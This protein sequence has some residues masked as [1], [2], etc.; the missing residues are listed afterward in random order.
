MRGTSAAAASTNEWTKPPKVATC[1][2]TICVDTKSTT[3]QNTWA[4]MT[5]DDQHH[6]HHSRSQRHEHYPS[7]HHLH[8]RYH[9]LP[10]LCGTLNISIIQ[11]IIFPKHLNHVTYPHIDRIELRLAPSYCTSTTHVVH[12][13]RDVQG[14]DDRVKHDDG[15]F[16]PPDHYS[17]PIQDTRLSFPMAS[18]EWTNIPESH[19][20]W[21]YIDA[22]V[23]DGPVVLGHGRIIDE[24]LDLVC[25]RDT[26]TVQWM[27]L[28]D[29]VTKEE[30]GMIQIRFDF[31]QHP[32]GHS[33][34]PPPPP[35]HHGA[36]D[37]DPPPHEAP[38][39]TTD[40]FFTRDV[41]SKHQDL[42]RS[43]HELKLWKKLFYALDKDQ[44]GYMDMTEFRSMVT[45]DDRVQTVLLSG[46]S[47]E[48]LMALFDRNGDG[49]GI[50]IPTILMERKRYE[51]ALCCR[52]YCRYCCFRSPHTHTHFVSIR[53]K[54]PLTNMSRACNSFS[55]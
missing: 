6:G 10:L 45:Q 44:S 9:V 42:V 27:P 22:I 48:P 18:F 24:V 14:K 40:A 43:A 50:H 23:F 36:N 19:D 51:S 31:H 33:P 53:R 28:R 11:T 5:M 55:T 13:Q 12:L 8:L 29:K 21:P 4:T 3:E 37:T 34:R 35:H 30:A 46:R 2:A 49:V 26:S 25:C 1:Y 52:L 39:S 20:E 32:H 41:N 17:Q 7:R 16:D 38:P 15:H 47:V 54:S